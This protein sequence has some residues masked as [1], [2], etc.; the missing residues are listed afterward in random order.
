MNDNDIFVILVSILRPAMQA[1][2]PDI[3]ILQRYQ[4]TQQGV[5]STPVVFIH[6]VVPARYGF[7]SSKS[8]YN[9]TD[10]DFDTTESTWR[11]P[12]FQVSALALRDP[13]APSLLT[14]SDICEAAADIMQSKS[15]RQALLAQNIGITRITD[16]RM[17]YFVNDKD[18][19]EAEP[20]FDFTLSYVNVVSTAK[21]PAVTSLDDASINVKRV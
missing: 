7:Q 9:D 21:T 1:L 15:T 14:A 2:S 3:E 20:S 5:P 12:T 16:M 4:P 19:H 11:T 6:K 8:V 17:T 13:E 18:Q 10:M